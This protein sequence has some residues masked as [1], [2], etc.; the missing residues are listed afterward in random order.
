MLDM[1][2]KN[3][4]SCSAGVQELIFN[5]GA[6]SPAP[7]PVPAGGGADPSTSS[8]ERTPDKRKADND[9]EVAKL[10]KELKAAE[11]ARDH[12][13]RT[14]EAMKVARD[15]RG[16][17]GKGGGRGGGG[18]QQQWYGPPVPY[19]SS[20][21]YSGDHHQNHGPPNNGGRGGDRRP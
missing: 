13:T 12:Q 1:K 11:T 5:S 14:C 10:R 20:G 19:Q 21:G 4:H 16:A 6:L 17:P 8:A 18:Y 15:R 9:T 3:N 7:T 2:M